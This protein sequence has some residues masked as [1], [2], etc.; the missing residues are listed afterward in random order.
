MNSAESKT[1]LAEE[2]LPEAIRRRLARKGGVGYLGDAVLG[3][4]DGCVTTFAVVTG[5]LGGGLSSQVALILGF[6]NLAADGFSMAVSN[7]E[8]AQSNREWVE[9]ARRREE[10]HLERI[11]E[12]E[13]EE[14]RQIYA[15]KGL[16]EPALGQVVAAVTQDR[17]L[18][19]DTMI[20]EEYGLPLESPVPWIS[21]ATTFL[22]FL[23]VG[24]IPLLPFLF[25]AAPLER[26]FAWSAGL[27]LSAF[28]AV[29]VLKGRILGKNPLAAGLQ[30]AF[31]GGAAASLSFAIG[32]GLRALVHAPP[33][34]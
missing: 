30:T 18:W 31:L 4:I 13:R 33:L 10:E 17:K 7:F 9:K 5:V 12:G 6:A 32:Y 29:G 26:H 27:T 8:R 19:I 20:A 15:R 1:P 25:Q 14:I 22:A 34:P 24:A 23:L 16:G 11:P 28:F 2:H 3:A 21:A